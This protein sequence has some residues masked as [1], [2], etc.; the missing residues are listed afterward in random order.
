MGVI[1]AI[2]I[3]FGGIVPVV[4]AFARPFVTIAGEMAA[5]AP[6]GLLLLGSLLLVS[7]ARR[8]HHRALATTGV[9]L[10]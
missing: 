1:V 10:R 7:R 5:F 4:T 9:S 6:A 8:R 3:I 2:A